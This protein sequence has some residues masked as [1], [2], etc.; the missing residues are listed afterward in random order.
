MYNSSHIMALYELDKAFRGRINRDQETDPKKTYY[1]I[2]LLILQHPLLGRLGRQRR[3]WNKAEQRP[4][5]KANIQSSFT[6]DRGGLPAFTV[7]DSFTVVGPDQ[8]RYCQ[9]TIPEDLQRKNDYVTKGNQINLDLYTRRY[10][11]YT[12]D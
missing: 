2:G 12:E 7:V 10:Y 9:L 5:G 1:K 11:L 3:V 6:V 8:V 4:E